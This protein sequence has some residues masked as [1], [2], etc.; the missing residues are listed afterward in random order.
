MLS[1]VAPS[2][3]TEKK[4]QPDTA[5]L[6]VQKSGKYPYGQGVSTC[7]PRS[8]R[9]INRARETDEATIRAAIPE[10]FTRPYRA[11]DVL[12]VIEMHPQW[13]TLYKTRRT[14][15]KAVLEALASVTD[16]DTM[17]TRPT[18]EYIIDRTG[19]PR[20]T[21]TRHLATLRSWGIVATIA[22][23]RSAAY[24]A[25]GPDGHKI[26]EAAV[27]VLCIPR[28]F[29]RGR[30]PRKL[31][32]HCAPRPVIHKQ[33]V[34]ENE[35]PPAVGDYLGLREKVTH[36]RAREEALAETATRS[37]IY[38]GGRWAASLER[39]PHHRQVILWSP[40]R[41]TASK[42]Q[43]LR[44]A[45]EL[46]RRF[47]AIFRRM[48]PADIGSVCRDHL[49]AG[50]TVKDITHALEY[51]PNGTRWPHT[52]SPGSTDPWCVRGWLAYRLAAWRR[53][54]GEPLTSPSQRA[55]VQRA[56]HAAQQRRHQEEEQKRRK[57][58]ASPDS[59]RKQAALARIRA[60]LARH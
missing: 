45:A 32:V 46:K 44:A 60:R 30:P 15:L 55:A 59:P 48:S 20:S 22:T 17:T 13:A 49:Q 5:G 53:A 50:W 6:R 39:Y 52:C 43:R 35:T 1:T 2:T 29:A 36:A 47:P 4:R 8:W 38:A 26:N 14:G 31:P 58:R 23:G 37:S 11:R 40:H 10:G 33:R 41:R 9:R 7:K 16:Y 27:Y 25:T 34:Q 12:D 21:M 18:W 24:A 42:K 57:H 3:Q 51:Q 28:R 54:E 56:E 19:I